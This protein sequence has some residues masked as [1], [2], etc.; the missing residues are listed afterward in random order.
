MPL[1]SK[2]RIDRARIRGRVTISDIEN[3]ILARLKRGAINVATGSHYERELKM[4]L[5][6]AHHQGKLTEALNRL[7]ATGKVKVV[8]LT[9]QRIEYGTRSKAVRSKG[10][11]KTGA[12]A[13]TVTNDPREYPVVRISIA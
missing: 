13:Y 12:V 11:T 6:L 10:A 1:S 8:E 2:E 7:K 4:R 3:D 5:G 9:G